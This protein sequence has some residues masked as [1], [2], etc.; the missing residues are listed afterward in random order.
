MEPQDK[1]DNV[2]DMQRDT[3]KGVIKEAFKEWLSEQIKDAKA[4]V[5]ERVINVVFGSL[6]L[7]CLWVVAWA[8]GWFK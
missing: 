6:I 4:T 1:K 5:G 3:L 7:A 8:N 2:F